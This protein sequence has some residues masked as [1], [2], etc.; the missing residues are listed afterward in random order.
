MF[1]PLPEKLSYSAQ[2]HKILDYWKHNHIFEKTLEARKDSP[3]YAFYEGP[4]TVNG[5][6]GVHHLMARTIKDTVCRYK[7]MR[8]FYVRRQAGWDTHGLP[9]EIAIG[10]QLGLKDKN[11]IEKFGIA[12]FNDACKK[13]VYENIEKAEGWSYLTER[14]GYWVDLNQAY[15]TCT[16]NYIESVWWSLKTFFDKNLIYRGFKVV[17]QSPTI[18]TPL[19]SHELSLGYKD[20]RDA[21]CYIKVKITKTHLPE[22]ANAQIMI[23]TTTPWTLFANVAA[24]IG[25]DIDYVHIRN[26]RKQKDEELIDE[27][28]IAEARLSVIDGE[29]EILN[30]YKGN[31]LLGIEYEQILPYANLKKEQFPQALTL[32]PGEFVST[33][34]GSGVVHLAPAFGEDDYQMSKIYDIPFVQPVTP[35]GHFTEDM[36]EFAGRA[37]KTFEYDDH[38]EEGADKDIV[39]ALK[40]AGKIYRST[41]DYLHSYPHCWRTGNPII[42][43]ARESWFIKSPEYKQDMIDRNK[44]INWQ[45]P[46][47]G[48]GRFGNWLDE[49]KEWALS[50]DRFWGTPLPIWVNTKDNED[51][52]AIGSIEE[53]KQ[54]FYE[55]ED[56]TSTA[57]PECGIE[58][59]LHRQFVDRVIFIRNG[60]TYRR[61]PEVIDVWYDSG[62]MPF[63]QLHYPFENKE[64]FDKIFPSDFIAEGIDQTRGWFYTLHNIA[65]ALFNKPAYKNIVVNELIL[66]KDGVKMSKSKGN[67]IDPYEVMEEFG[68]D[69]VRWY[70]FVNSPPWKPTKFDKSVLSKTVISDFL[71]S[72]TNTYSFFTLYANIDGFT[73]DEEF[74]EFENRPEI[75]RWVISRTNSLLKNYLEL[76]D[77]YELT[78][79]NR[80]VQDF[81]MND[82]SNWY[83]RRNRRR[84]W[85]GE[86]DNDKI[87][88]YQTLHYVLMRL[89]EMI[90]PTAPFIAEDLYRRLGGKEESVHLLIFQEPD[91]SLI[92]SKLEHKMDLA[93]QISSLTRALREKSNLRVRQPLQRILLP[94]N[95]PAERR[96]IQSVAEIIKEEVNIKSIDFV[97]DETQSIISKTA[98]GNFK[99]IGKKFGKNTQPVA[100]FIKELKDNQIRLLESGGVINFTA[101][102]T[103][104]SISDEDVEIYNQDIEGW[105]VASEGTITVALDTQLSEELVMEGNAREFI[106]RIQNLRKDSGFNVTD[107]IGIEY[108]TENDDLRKAIENMSEYIQNETLAE[109]V[110]YKIDLNDSIKIDLLETFVHLKIKKIAE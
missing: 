68:A 73:G 1:E 4:P 17:P 99:V 45:P 70:L 49:V 33:E 35:N 81:I 21:N 29:F 79:A 95:S 36:G 67:A 15:I 40:H 107:R 94:V 14:M 7:T 92:N 64:L 110:I 34:N 82:L 85:K 30:R 96:A 108:N 10:K 52:F 42:Y 89:V 91:E 76:M 32:L 87:A 27:L 16:N 78:K 109:Y 63:A 61:V 77:A 56:G 101:N 11:D 86:K 103:E 57:V 102:D 47:I 6:P 19:S 72:L 48:E 9:V 43:Y 28:I 84:F 69:A 98:K 41:N 80:A 105:L 66:D 59:D 74:I 50:R 54:G 18:E 23:W 46:E 20:V 58:I 38:T 106:N 75:D 39:I 100:N 71:R 2:E 12:R 55:N 65:V 97:T 62:A 3:Y 5:M 8:G 83:I 88:A 60:I 37:V 22:L 53:L 25:E 90:A 26:T 104:L 31:Q 51:Y 93:Q 44:E 13:F 24:A